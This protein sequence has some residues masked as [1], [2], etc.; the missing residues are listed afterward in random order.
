M[1][2]RVDVDVPLCRFRHQSAQ[3]ALAANVPLNPSGVRLV[4]A[5]DDLEQLR[6]AFL[7][8]QAAGPE[9]VEFGPI[10][11]DR[12]L[13]SLGLFRISDRVERVRDLH[14]R[15]PRKLPLDRRSIAARDSV[16]PG[17]A[18]GQ[19][20]VKRRGVEE[21]VEPAVERARADVTVRAVAAE[22]DRRNPMIADEVVKQKRLRDFV[23][24][25][26]EVVLAKRL[27]EF[28]EVCALEVARLAKLALDRF[29]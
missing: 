28:A 23:S 12:R 24:T 4:H 3:L 7:P 10:H 27:G 22:D 8:G 13:G 6:D 19:A 15:M 5:F 29:A 18:L 26:D 11:R 9:D 14:H 21:I 16:K 2:V 17:H 1:A 20:G 25:V